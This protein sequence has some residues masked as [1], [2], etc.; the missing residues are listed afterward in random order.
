LKH[1]TNA[2]PKLSRRRCPRLGLTSDTKFL[3]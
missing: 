3:L 2:N 1:T